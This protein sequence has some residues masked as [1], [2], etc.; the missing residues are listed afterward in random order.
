MSY[1]WKKILNKPIFDNHMPYDNKSIYNVTL[2][3][4][5]SKQSSYQS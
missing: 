3:L 1:K 2:T 4:F 5:L